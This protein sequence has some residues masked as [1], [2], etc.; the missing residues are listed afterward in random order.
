MEVDEAFISRRKY[1]RGRR[2]AK[3]GM[4]VVGL[5]EVNTSTHEIDDPVLLEAIKEREAKRRA[6]SQRPRCRFKKAKT[7]ARSTPTAFSQSSVPFDVVEGG[8]LLDA[9]Q[10]N[11][12][13]EGLEREI[14]TIFSQRRKGRPKKDPFPHRREQGRGDVNTHCQEV[15]PAWFNCFH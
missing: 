5:T 10:P 1:N 15:C 11:E 9:N 13:L 12:E 3:E 2:Q 6:W 7:A 4:W 8:S 14:Q